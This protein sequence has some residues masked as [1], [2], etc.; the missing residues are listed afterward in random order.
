MTRI[1]A[2]AAFLLAA[3]LAPA[4]L[5][6]QENWAGDWHGT[7]AT[8]NGNL[9]LVLTIRQSEGA[10]L[11]A[12]LE[13]PD[14]APGRK[15]PVSPIA[16]ADGRMTF[17]IPMIGASYEGRWQAGAGRFTGTFTQ[18]SR[19]PLDF[20]RGSGEARPVIAGLDGVWQGIVNRNGVDLRLIVRI[21]SGPL[22]TIATFDSPDLMAYGLPVGELSRDGRSVSF[23]V[24]ASGA[25]YRGTLAGDG[26]RMTGTWSRAG[27]PDAEVTFV[28]SDRAAGAAPPA[29]PQLPRPPFPYRSEEVRFANSRA[30]GVTLAGT[31]TLP[32]GPGPLA[33]AILISGSGPQ[34]RDET[35]LGHKPFAVLAD[36]LTRQGIAVLRYDDRGVGAS[37]G[38]Q[39]GATS[40]DFAT[41]ANAAFAYLRS[42]SEIDPRAIGFVGHSEGGLIGPL[43]AV[44]NAE[45]AYLVLMAGPGTEIGALIETQRRALGQSQG[46]SEAELDRSAPIQRQLYEISASGRSDA[47]AEAAIRAVLSE[48]AMT[49]AGLPR[50][51][52]DGMIQRAVD[53]WFRWFARY[54]PA[55]VLARIRVPV[56][57]IN[58]ALDRQV[59]AA[60]NLAG[61]R[62]AMA[63]NADLTVAELPGLNHLFQTAR[64]GALGE[65]AD[66]EETMAP[67]ALATIAGWIKA[68]FPPPDA[69]SHRH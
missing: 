52:R 5:Q 57:A 58:G 47:D 62:A 31:L 18:G 10:A 26:S 51:M 14:Q 56:L 44:D 35:L 53:P 19:L 29:R 8:P 16:I 11:A 49:Q 23:T 2:F 24:T 39:A 12:E 69:N 43:A 22:G 65:Y 32:P 41:D 34:D 46:M 40:A 15:I 63:G 45:V 9:R 37:T 3:L 6:A 42:R 21:A 60:E 48:E 61:I 67:V 55:P 68:R 20:A 64:T 30:P 28:R 27:L 1:L 38:A 33:A 25:S 50:Q 59:I 4:A 7:L 66:I 54:D 36:Q 13:S 17:S